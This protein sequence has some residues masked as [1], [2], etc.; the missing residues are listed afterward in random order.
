M[1]KRRRIG[2]ARRRLPSE[3]VAEIQTYLDAPTLLLTRLVSRRWGEAAEEVVRRSRRP[4]LVHLNL[5]L[6]FA[7]TLAVLG[8]SSSETLR[9]IGQLVDRMQSSVEKK[10]KATVSAEEV[11]VFRAYVA[12]G[13]AA[14]EISPAHQ[15]TL[16][17]GLEWLVV[18]RYQK[19]VIWS[20]ASGHKYKATRVGDRS[21][22]YWRSN[23]AFSPWTDV[24]SYRYI[25]SAA[26][27]LVAFAE[28]TLCR[29]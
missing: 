12:R 2:Y 16:L 19:A 8:D 10:V 6:A 28:E 27:H 22:L 11:A 1:S 18:N 7:R 4:Q 26:S 13:S 29:H 15:A 25:C 9:G 21:S 3:I 24:P 14:G 17:N 5:K 20:Y 23:V